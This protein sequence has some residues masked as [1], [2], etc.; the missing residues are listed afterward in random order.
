MKHKRFIVIGLGQFGSALAPELARLGGEVL[1]VDIAPK[2]VEAIRDEVAMAA[3]ADVR[4]KNGLKELITA[5]FDYAIIAIGGS[6]EAS[7]LATLHL[8]ELAVREIYAE[9]NSE[10]R[11][12]VL[13]R[14]G[15][16]AVI[17]PER[18]MGKRL[19]HRLANPNMLDFLSLAEGYGVLRVDAPSWTHG[20]SLQE[21]ELRKKMKLTVIAIRTAGDKDV[22]GPGAHQ[23]VQKGDEIV[24]VGADTDLVKFKDHGPG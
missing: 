22:I 21:L 18:D 1:A 11:A 16:S 7:I 20:K 9:A 14:V 17:S 5:T 19:A 13:R 24:L 3:V 12:E 4:D 10:E 8:K 15:A 23:V 6:L 2:R